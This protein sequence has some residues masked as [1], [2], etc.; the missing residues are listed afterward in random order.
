MISSLLDFHRLLDLDTL[1]SSEV[2]SL[3]VTVESENIESIPAVEVMLVVSL[4]IEI[5]LIDSIFSF[6]N[7]FMHTS[8]PG[9]FGKMGMRTFHYKANPHHCPSLNIDR[10]WSLVTE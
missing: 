10:I 6:D 1:E 7:I 2:M 3:W 9:Y 4:I 5:S 8:H